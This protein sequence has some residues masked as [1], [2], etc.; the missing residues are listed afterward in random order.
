MVLAR[1]FFVVGGGGFFFFW[2][3]LNY[4][5]H[6]IEDERQNRKIG[7]EKKLSLGDVLCGTSLGLE[8][9]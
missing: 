3:S 4:R 2:L 5:N 9:E 8:R 6:I 1:V 7:K